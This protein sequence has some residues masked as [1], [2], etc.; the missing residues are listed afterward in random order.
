MPSARLPDARGDA[1]VTPAGGVN[2][3]PDF[4]ITW[5]SHRR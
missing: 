4:S 5:R 3:A 1:G 2:F